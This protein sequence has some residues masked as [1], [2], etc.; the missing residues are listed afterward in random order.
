LTFH[1]NNFVESVGAR[2]IHMTPQFFP[3]DKYLKLKFSGGIILSSESNTK[4]IRIVWCHCLDKPKQEESKKIQNPKDNHE[5]K[6]IQKNKKNQE[7]YVSR[8][9]QNSIKKTQEKLRQDNG[10][11]IHKCS[12]DTMSS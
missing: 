5:S 8:T 1:W 9:D 2:S 12:S 7:P 4:Q 10:M 3:R 11:H 6:K